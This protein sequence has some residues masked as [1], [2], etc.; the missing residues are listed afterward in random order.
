MSR[1]GGGKRG[2]GRGGGERACVYVDNFHTLANPSAPSDALAPHAGR[3]PFLFAT[4]PPPHVPPPRHGRLPQ[5]CDRRAPSAVVA[6]CRTRS[7]VRSPAAPRSHP[8]DSCRYT[9]SYFRERHSRSMNTL[10]IHRPRPSIEAA[11]TRGLPSNPVN[12]I[13]VQLAALI[14]VEDLRQCRSFPAPPPA[15]PGRTTV[16]IVLDNRHAST[17]RLA[18][19]M[20]RHQVQ[21]PALHRDVGD[22][23]A[24]HLIRSTQSVSP[25]DRPGI[26]TRCSTRWRRWSRGLR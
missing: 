6:R 9:A 13:L 19:S 7:T 26:P 2:W 23:R 11:Y 10:S 12:A 17:R 20:M 18:Q 25:A 24:P 1:S 14:G 16:S 8:P 22:V 5:A 3:L 15:P 4:P 21:E